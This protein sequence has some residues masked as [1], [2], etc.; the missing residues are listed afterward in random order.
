M[1]GVRSFIR[2]VKRRAWC[3]DCPKEWDGANALAVAARHTAAHG[4]TTEA[5]TSTEHAYIPAPRW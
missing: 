2:T 4:H 3:R 1:N 5:E